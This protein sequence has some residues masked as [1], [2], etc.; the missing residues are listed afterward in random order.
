MTVH[1][2]LEPGLYSVFVLYD[3]QTWEQPTYRIGKGLNEHSFRSLV[4]DRHPKAFLAVGVDPDDDC[5]EEYVEV[6]DD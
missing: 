5:P 6:L 2:E 1:D 4:L 3:N